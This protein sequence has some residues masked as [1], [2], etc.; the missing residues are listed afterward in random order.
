LHYRCSVSLRC[1]SPLWG[2]DAVIGVVVH[3]QD[4]VP[5]IAARLNG[6]GVAA[7]AVCDST[8]IGNQP[9]WVP[10]A[11]ISCSPVSCS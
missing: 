10:R 7:I 3:V 6:L 8:G 9:A 2:R 1:H 5:N 11:R 4:Q